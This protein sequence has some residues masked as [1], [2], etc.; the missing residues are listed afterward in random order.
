MAKRKSNANKKKTLI[1]IISAVVLLLAAA[2][3][4]VV[5]V[6]GGE[7]EIPSVVTDEI[8]T[9]EIT[10][11]ETTTTAPETE[12]AVVAEPEPAFAHG[13]AFSFVRKDMGTKPAFTD[14]L[15][16]LEA[17]K[18]LGT[19]R[20]V[21]IMINN[22]EHAI[23]QVG[24]SNADVL[25]E[26]LAEGGITRLLM[27]TRDYESLGTVGSIR[28]SREY[29]IDFAKNH[30]AIYIHA[31]GSE[32]AY[33]QI[34]S[35]SI[36]HLD[37]VRADARTGKNMSGTVFYRDPD[38]LK[39]FAYEHTMVTTGER[40]VK[41]IE[42]MGYTK[43]L[44]TGFNEPIKPIDW[45]W[46]VVLSGENA[47]KVKIPYR[48]NRVSEYEYD[49]ATGKYMRYQFNHQKHVDGA[50]GEQLSFENIFILNMPH[51][52]TGDYA[53]HLVVT[54]TGTGNGW[55]ITGGKR[56]PITW[57][58]PSQDEPMTVCDAE[59]NPIV[60]NQGKTAINIV[61]NGVWSSVS[62]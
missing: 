9:D 25:Y 21:A 35:R 18:D 33:S 19:T 61:D 29:Y 16:G 20:P 43:Q 4:T 51:R 52:N 31:G 14:P 54:T 24:I 1:I 55:Y 44:K 36:E 46:S 23:P 39:K 47:T 28:S 40:I 11:F 57:S 17:T 50:N 27:V 49:A 38:R 12:P 56:I 62:F 34:Y 60:I 5:L 2:I 26:C 48:S 45:G 32:K 41:G 6:T 59:G 13:T 10:G 42:A 53:G 7:K 8:T 15:T 3:V 37:G 30:D 22:I 58:K